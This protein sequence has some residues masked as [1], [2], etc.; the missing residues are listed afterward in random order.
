MENYKL[1]IELFTKEAIE[2]QSI[3]ERICFDVQEIFLRNPPRRNI[4]TDL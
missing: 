2:T 1:V 3:G 4:S